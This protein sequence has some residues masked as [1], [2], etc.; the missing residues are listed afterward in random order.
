M[1]PRRNLQTRKHR[2]KRNERWKPM[3]IVIQCIEGL[4]EKIRG[5]Q[6]DCIWIDELS[7]LTEATIAGVVSRC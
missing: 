1:N 5:M 4:P 2:R 3:T 7:D 6:F